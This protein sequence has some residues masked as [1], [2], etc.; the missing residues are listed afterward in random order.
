MATTYKTPGVYIEEIVK[1]PPS[2]AQVETAIPAFIGY[3]EK[4]KEKEE[5]LTETLHMDPKRITSMLEYEVHFGF[6][7]KE[8]AL[9]ITITEVDGEK[10]ITVTEPVEDEKSPFLMYYAMQMYFANGGGPCYVVSVNTY[11]DAIANNSSTPVQF[12]DLTDGLNTL[13]KEDEP[14]LLLFPDATSLANEA[15]FYNLY[16]NAL[17]QCKK[18]QDRFS[19]IDTYTD[20]EDVEMNEPEGVRNLI[21]S[22]IDEKKYGAVYFPYLKT[23]LDY[24]YDEDALEITHNTNQPVLLSGT[25]DLLTNI[26]NAQAAMTGLVTT[27]TTEDTALQAMTAGDALANSS[28]ITNALTPIIESLSAIVEDTNTIVSNAR[29][30]AANS[31]EDAVVSA[32]ATAAADALAVVVEDSSTIATLITSL[33][34]HLTTI[35]EAA[36]GTA[37]KTESANAVL[38]LATVDA[39]IDAVEALITPPVITAI[40]NAQAVDPDSGN[41]DGFKLSAI[42]DMDSATYNNIKTAINN[43]P[44]ELPPSS[45]MAGIYARVDNDRGVW[46][47]PANVS[48]KYTV[49][50]SQKITNDIQDRLNVDTTAGKSINAIR[51]FTGKGTLVWGSRTLAGNDKEWRYVP[52]RRFFNMA[53]ESIKKATEQFVFEPNDRNTWVR[54]KAMINNFLTL[55]WRAGAL[56]GPTPDKAFYVNVGLGETMTANDVLDGK[57]IIEIGMAVVRPAE[58]I[59]LRFS[60]KMQEA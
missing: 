43:L 56:A 20:D 27:L 50:P 9:G 25:N 38:A 41:L 17:A 29:T 4:A 59:I 52:V 51:T 42:K 36:N 24:H 58:F 60:H 10:S 32:A 22:D 46:K 31:N 3:T 11:A 34:T 55:Q 39:T 48:V 49:K 16:N 30:A 14:T 8:T 45:A 33:G 37:V 40:T 7:Q 54:V 18:M 1:F 19:I 5:D 6:P 23:I 57:M 35:Q 12:N 44:L 47:A 13:E 2:V 28:T 26:A 21:T 15:D 53:E